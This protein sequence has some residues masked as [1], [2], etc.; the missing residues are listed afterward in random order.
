MTGATI[1]GQAFISVSGAG[2]GYFVAGDH[3]GI[4]A[5]QAG[6]RFVQWSS[7]GGPSGD[8]TFLNQ[9]AAST[10]FVMPDGDVT[11]TAHLRPP[12]RLATR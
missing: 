9:Y 6:Y 7:S 12:D 4:T 5:V 2:D 3:V 11:V 8:G 1:G 10:T